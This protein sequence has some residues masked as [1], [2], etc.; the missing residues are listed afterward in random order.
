MKLNYD[1][2][3]DIYKKYLTEGPDSKQICGMWSMS[4][5]P[6]SDDIFYSSQIDEIENKFNLELSE[7]DVMELYDM[8]LN[9]AVEYIEKLKKE[10]N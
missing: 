9:E 10:N 2:L 8:D 1:I 6:D 3:H 4:N 5:P 7:D